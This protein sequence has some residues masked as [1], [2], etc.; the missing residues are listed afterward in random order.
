[1][2]IMKKEEEEKHAKTLQTVAAQ[3]SKGERKAP[4]KADR[5]DVRCLTG[6]EY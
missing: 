6:R 3:T 4:K 5:K 2:G 1:M